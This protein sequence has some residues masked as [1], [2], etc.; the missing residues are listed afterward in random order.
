[1]NLPS[2]DRLRVEAW[3][4][5][6]LSRHIILSEYRLFF[7]GSRVTDANPSRSDIDVGI[8]KIG[9][10][11]LPPGVLAEMSEYVRELPTLYKI[12]FIDFGTVAEEFRDVA[13]QEIE[14][15]ST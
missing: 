5:D 14:P 8:E 3:I 10:G 1:M 12:D 11:T 13:L 15:F 6:G 7:F 9:G 4:R 2:D